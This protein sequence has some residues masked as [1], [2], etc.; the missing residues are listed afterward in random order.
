MVGGGPSDGGRRWDGEDRG[1]IRLGQV[2]DRSFL[3]EREGGSRGRWKGLRMVKFGSKKEQVQ[4]THLFS[5]VGER[6]FVRMDGIMRWGVGKHWDSHSGD[7]TE[8]ARDDK[9]KNWTMTESARDDKRKGWMDKVRWW[10]CV[11]WLGTMV[12][13]RLGTLEVGKVACHGA[14]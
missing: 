10:H 8:T 12:V 14:T 3:S 13:P 9:M 6:S 2:K 7:I 4:E 11:V 5:Q 1:Q